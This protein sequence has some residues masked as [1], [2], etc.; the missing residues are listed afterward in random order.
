MRPAWLRGDA[1]WAV[2]VA[3]VAVTALT[4]LASSSKLHARPVWVWTAF[5][6][7]LGDNPHLSVILGFL[8][9]LV[10]PI[11]IRFGRR[12]RRVRA[13]ADQD[14]PCGASAYR[15][16]DT[17][18]VTLAAEMRT[19]LGRGEFVPYYQPIVSL[20][21]G[22]LIGFESLARWEHPER[23]MIGPDSFIRQAEDSG[24]IHE[25]CLT[26][27]ERA[28]ADMRDW[29]APLT[30]SINLSPLQFGQAWMAPRILKTL[31]ANGIAP[32][33]LIV[34]LTE[35]RSIVDFERARRVLGSL[36]FAGV[37]V[38]LDDFGTGYS[39]LV[40]L[41]ELSFDRIKIDRAFT[42]ELGR[43]ENTEII[44]ALLSLGDGLGV[45]VVAEGVETPGVAARLAQL[46]CTY[47]QGFL[48][49]PPISAEAALELIATLPAALLSRP[50]GA[51]TPDGA[52]NAQLSAMEDVSGR[53]PYSPRRISS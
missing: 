48:Y 17:R 6:Q 35:S 2:A 27:L 21:N 7:G 45:P 47:A 10:L 31:W 43:A 34:E 15:A 1:Q 9:A 20:E 36:K 52:A 50:S 33:R 13:E 51:T 5:R 16:T 49:S 4:G 38:A 37:Q 29:P 53:A 30:L 32:G 40:R 26:L 39:S 22:A 28:C 41:R 12:S 3:I 18:H 44:R 8:L 23:G 14:A 25:L 46:G 11:L 42:S 24:L 19:G